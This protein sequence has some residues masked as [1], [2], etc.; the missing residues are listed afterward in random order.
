MAGD[1]GFAAIPEV[2]SGTLAAA[3]RA[4]LTWEATYAA[5]AEARRVSSELVQRLGR[6]A[7]GAP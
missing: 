4:A 5:D 1:L 6:T 2:L 7:A 3:P